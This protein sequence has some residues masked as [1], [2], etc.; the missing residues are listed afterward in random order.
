MNKF[1]QDFSPL[2]VKVVTHLYLFHGLLTKGYRR[3]A[4]VQRPCEAERSQYY[5]GRTLGQ[6]CPDRSPEIKMAKSPNVQKSEWS[7]VQMDR[8][9]DNE[10][11]E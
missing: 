10:K 1:E 8:G 5:T 3:M 7:E 4:F 11:S 2:C 6:K 9:L